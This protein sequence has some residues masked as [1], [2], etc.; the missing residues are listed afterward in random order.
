MNK[1]FKVSVTAIALGIGL[2]GCNLLNPEEETS[3]PKVTMNTIGAITAGNFKNVTGEITADEVITNVTYAIT[4]SAGVAVAKTVIDYKG[5]TVRD[6]KKFEF[7]DNNV[8]TITPAATATAGA[9]K[10]KLTVTAGST[11]DAS[12]DFTVAAGSGPVGTAVVSATIPAGSNSNAAY[13]S[14]IDLDAG[15]AYKM[16]DAASHVADLDLCYSTTGTGTDK[17]GSPNWAK[18]SDFNYAKNWASPAATKFYKTALTKAQFDA[19]TTREQIPAFVDASATAESY[20]AALND[21]FLVKTTQSAIVLVLI[22]EKTNG[23]N[24][25]ITIKSS[26]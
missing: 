17:L 23:A 26:K 25:S 18:L 22:N 24:G 2:V 10:L 20:E 14:S 21:V 13:G 7:K 9:Y 8:I 6:V 15:V 5:P 1:F 11:V 3:I 12:F 19:I 16:A 4:T